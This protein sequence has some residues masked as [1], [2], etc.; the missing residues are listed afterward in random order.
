MLIPCN[1]ELFVAVFHLSKMNKYYGSQIEVAKSSRTQETILR[2]TL[3]YFG[4]GT[5]LKHQKD[6]NPLSLCSVE[7]KL[8]VAHFSILFQF[9]RFQLDSFI[10]FRYSSCSILSNLRFIGFLYLEQT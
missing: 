2:L 3:K 10:F 6:E 5:N 9:A 4:K 7:N 8:K 1:F